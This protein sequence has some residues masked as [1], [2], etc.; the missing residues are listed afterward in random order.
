MNADFPSS[1]D[2]EIKFLDWFTVWDLAR[3]GVAAS[4]GWYL[5]GIA[6]ATVG[7]ILG[8]LLGR[9]QVGDDSLGISI[10][11]SFHRLVTTA[12]VSPPAPRKF[13][14][15][16]IILDNDTAVGIVSVDSWEIEYASQPAKQ[17]NRD[18]VAELLDGITYPVEIH[19][20]QRLVDVSEYQGADG[21]AVTTDHY[22]VVRASESTVTESHRQVKQRCTEVRN[23]LTAG[24]LSADRLTGSELKS[25]MDRLHMGDRV[26]SQN[27]YTTESGQKQVRRVLYVDEF[28]DQLPF[29]WLAEVLNRET[30]GLVDV[31]Q[32][33]RPVA[34]H[35]RDWMNRMLARIK[36]EVSASRSPSRQAR[37]R[38]QERDLED[39]I[40]AEA[41]RETLVNYGVCIVARGDS[42][43]EAEQTIADVQSVLNRFR[44]DHREPSRL[45]HAVKAV[46]ALH[47]RGAINSEIVPG[48]SAATGFSFGTRGTL[49]SGGITIGTQRTGMPVI[50]DRF[51]WE[52]GHITVM[53]KIGSGK[54][55]WTGLSLI[56]SV[57]AYDDLEI[58]VIDPKKRDYGDIVGALDGESILIDHEELSARPTDVMRYTVE[59]PSQDNTQRL[60]ETV[61]HVY[62]QAV[63][64]DSKTLV[65]IDEAHRIIT[66]GD[67]IYDSGLRA[68]S[69]LVR[70]TRE[71]DV[72]VTLITQNADEFTRSNEGR[73][74]LRNVDCNLFFKQKNVASQIADFFNLS[75]KEADELRKL[76]TGTTLPFSEALVRGP[77]NTRLRI[78]AQPDE[79][80]LLEDG[81]LQ[82][83]L[84]GSPTSDTE[85]PTETETDQPPSRTDG[86]HDVQSTDAHGANTREGMRL[87]TIIGNT[88]RAPIRLFEHVLVAGFPI[89]WLL[90]RQNALASLLSLSE[91]PLNGT[92]IDVLAVWT[93][94]FIGIEL[95][96]VLLLSLTEWLGQSWR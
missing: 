62:R 59:D 91:L 40:D 63:D 96:W 82:G 79:H 10:V 53:G 92:L 90:Y 51:S 38:E 46:S 4:T 54:T 20:R 86:G 84:F 95:L 2:P 70:E 85:G 50:L 41:G 6:G 12:T 44:V 93:V 47:K 75:E 18:T 67:Q 77:V 74:V 25:A 27:G 52:A 66:N 19:S 68:V 43:S 7:V 36:A 60:A 42:P 61:E 31:V 87:L 89:A 15:G 73:N 83:G 26:L 16:S 72:G 71:K 94:L 17:A 11:H 48:Y 81:E 8:V 21:P 24:D 57:Q 65:V 9:F 37:L 30:P 45:T 23:L 1:I 29:G 22:V 80:R 78:D 33:V 3:V 28:P 55:Y 88:L 32:A 56:R 35:Q 49:E 39:L 76:R 14:D 34:D 5:G 64:S 13:V 58:Y 69:T